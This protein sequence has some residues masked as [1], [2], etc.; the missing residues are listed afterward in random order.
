MS[1]L[2]KIE[3]DII[4]TRLANENFEFRNWYLSGVNSI[5]NNLLRPGATSLDN[6]TYV[7]VKQYIT[8]YLGKGILQ[9]PFPCKSTSI[10]VHSIHSEYCQ[11]VRNRAFK[12]NIN[13]SK[14]YL[15]ILIAVTWR[16]NFGPNSK[17]MNN[18]GAV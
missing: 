10:Q 12:N 16:N 14:E 6:H 18:R 2:F 15:L 4:R 17:C 8:D 5:C 9:Q 7:S 1:T 13:V 3:D 11:E